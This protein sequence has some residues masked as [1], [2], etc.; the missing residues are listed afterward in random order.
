MKEQLGKLNG[1]VNHNSNYNNELSQLC[2]NYA[3]Y[4]VKTLLL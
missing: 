2:V 4:F 1:L 3:I